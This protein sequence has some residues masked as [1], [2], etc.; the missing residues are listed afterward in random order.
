MR[1]IAC[2]FVWL[3]LITLFANLDIAV[4]SEPPLPEGINTSE[5]NVSDEP[6]LPEGLQGGSR[7]KAGGS[8]EPALPTG[9]GGKKEEGKREEPSLPTGLGTSQGEE[10]RGQIETAEQA[11]MRLPWIDLNGF[12]EARGGL[13]TQSDPHEPD[14]SLAEIRLQLEAEEVYRGAVFHGKVD[15]LYDSVVPSQAVDL[16]LGYGW[17]DIREA[18]VLLR[19]T[20]FMDLQAGRQV[21]TWGVGDLIFINDLFPKDWN[22]FFLGRDVEY[23]KAP[24]DALKAALYTDW[25][26]VDVVYTPAFDSDRY[27]DGRMISYFN[28]QTL[29]SAGRNAI[30]NP[31]GRNEWFEDDEIAVRVYQNVNAYELALY[32]YDGFWK[33]PNGFDPV[34]GR[35]TFPRLSVYGA[36]ARG[37][38]WEGIGSTEVGYYDSRDDRGGGD[39]NVRNSEIRYLLGYEQ[40]LFKNFTAGVQ[41]YLEYMLDYDEYEE[42]LVAGFPAREEDRHVLTL[43]LT[44][45]L[46]NQN[47]ELSFFGYY[48]PSDEDAYLRP[49]VHYKVDD[50]WSVS[51][52]GNFFF[53]RN[54][55][56][57]YAQFEDNSNVW[58][59]VRYS[60]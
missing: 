3:V 11:R 46:M 30:V 16:E 42:N 41:Y 43:R 38:I 22:S 12:L 45:L 13:R 9:L 53:G 21:L 15:F 51:S 28:E 58:A 25:V 1:I 34:S 20:G 27:I 31:E 39:R 56:T 24:S 60:F 50:R 44:Q 36:S 52:G 35:A 33:S 29:R 8:E 6:A 7:E 47:L 40:E 55:H 37:P 2:T 54:G 10:S 48:S 4:G 57:F 49:S 19:P 32:G 14:T 5:K 18:S 17:V 59:A 23:L 26:N